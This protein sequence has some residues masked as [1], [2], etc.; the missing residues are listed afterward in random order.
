MFI[1]NV[2]LSWNTRITKDELLVNRMQL[3][4]TANRWH[5]DGKDHIDNINVKY[6]MQHRMINTTLS[7][8]GAISQNITYYS[9]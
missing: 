7:M 9:K 1:S 4:S 2:L 8:V 6:K 5:S 3:L